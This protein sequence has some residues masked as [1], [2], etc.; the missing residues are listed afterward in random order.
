MAIWVSKCGEVPPSANGH[1]SL[2][3]DFGLLAQT[4][5]GPELTRVGAAAPSR[6]GLLPVPHLL[7]GHMR[8]TNSAAPRAWT[9]KIP[10]PSLSLQGGNRQ[11]G[12][13]RP[14]TRPPCPSPPGCPHGAREGVDGQ[15]PLRP[16]SLRLLPAGWRG[17]G[18]PGA[19][20]HGAS[21]G[22]SH[23]RQSV[24]D[25]RN[26]PKSSRGGV[27][28]SHSGPWQHGLSQPAKDLAL[29]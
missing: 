17:A 4:H 20:C 19:V 9:A 14:P 23:A 11:H 24:S 12:P 10:F 7:R 13:S 5:T 1:G 6:L 15:R 26:E 8:L 22:G 3:S 29:L 18:L 27:E 2:G 28:S 25:G 21:A 16:T